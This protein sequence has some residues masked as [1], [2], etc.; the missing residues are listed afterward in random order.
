MP[1][2]EFR[3]EEVLRRARQ[4]EEQ[5]QLELKTLTDEQRRLNERL[6]G[7]HEKEE[8]QLRTMAARYRAGGIEPAEIDAA[9]TYLSSIELSITDHLDVAAGV[10]AR[11]LES[12][13]QLIEILREKQSLQ[14]LKRR[15][16]DA[17]AI[18]DGRREAKADD[19]M[20]SVRFA[21]RA[22]EA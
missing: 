4:Q 2:P 22:K 8:H 7:L 13:D 16:Q 20:T 10:Q 17:A 14:N 9:L 21:R 11:V 1:A 19:D 12:R 6:A 18:E 3:L 5:K 15:H